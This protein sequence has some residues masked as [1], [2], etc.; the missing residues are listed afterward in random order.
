MINFT[1]TIL[2]YCIIS[3]RMKYCHRIQLWRIIK[4]LKTLHYNNIIL[5]EEIFKGYGRHNILEPDSYQGVQ[6]I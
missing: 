4:N 6:V 1:L 2:F 3:G 5:N